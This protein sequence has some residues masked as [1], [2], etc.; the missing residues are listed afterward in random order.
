[1]LK[2]MDNNFYRLILLCTITL[3]VLW[4]GTSWAQQAKSEEKQK[5][6]SQKESQSNSDKEISEPNESDYLRKLAQ[7]WAGGPGKE[8]NL[9]EIFLEKSPEPKTQNWK[10]ESSFKRIIQMFGLS[11]LACILLGTILGYLGTHVLR[12]EIIFIDISL[13]QFAAVGATLAHFAVE[14]HEEHHK[15]FLAALAVGAEKIVHLFSQ[16]A[17]PNHEL[18]ESVLSYGCSFLCVMIIALFYAFAKKKIVQISLEAIIGVTYAV[19]SAAVLF[20]YGT[21]ATEH[22]HIQE[23][24]AGNLLWIESYHIKLCLVLFLAVALCFL[25]FHKPL[26]RLSDNYRRLSGQGLKGFGWDFLFYTL[27]GMVV[28]VAIEIAG[29]IMVFAYLIIPATIAAMFTRRLQWQLLII[30]L[31][32][33]VCSAFGLIFSHFYEDFSVGPPI[34]MCLGGML[35]LAAL[36]KKVLPQSISAVNS[37]G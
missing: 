31:I 16:E 21:S 9:G 19:A 23:M 12:R 25:I 2:F 28:T 29:V 1:M 11:F 36:L 6:L 30:A 26:N 20:L 34:G 5:L 14:Y 22:V 10:P 24:L 37:L 35:I 17:E 33:T 7:Q 8:E 15:H 4:P 13:A 3:L 18:V 32:T 27:M